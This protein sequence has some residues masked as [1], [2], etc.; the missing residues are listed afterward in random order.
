APEEAL[1]DAMLDPL[2][3]APVTRLIRW[4][5]TRHLGPGRTCTHDPQDA[6][7]NRTVI[8]TWSSTIACSF[9]QMCFHHCPLFVGD[10]HSFAP[11]RALNHIHHIFEMTSR[12]WGTGQQDPRLRD[13][14][15]PHG[16]RHDRLSAGARRRPYR[17]LCTG[18]GEA[19][20]G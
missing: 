19:D 4:V 10:V 8:L 20:R 12:M 2:L 15:P 5:A 18:A 3:V 7:K 11:L 6:V 16:A 9:G 17:G 14:R 1:N 13:D